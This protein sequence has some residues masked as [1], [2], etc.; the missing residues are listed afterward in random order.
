MWRCA[1]SY[2]PTTRRVTET[3]GDGPNRSRRSLFTAYPRASGTR[4]HDE[5]GRGHH[6]L[7]GPNPP[8]AEGEPVAEQCASRHACCF[9]DRRPRD[10]GGADP[11]AV[12]R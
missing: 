11:V 12:G 5:H 6:D 3:R 7:D 9:V 4:A 1:A 2:P 8:A 10:V